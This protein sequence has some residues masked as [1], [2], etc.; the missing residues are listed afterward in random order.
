MN[1][2]RLSAFSLVEVVIALGIFA[3][4]AVGI[5]GLLPVAMDATRAVS[6]EC[7][8]N[9]IAESISGFWQVSANGSNSG[10]DFTMGDFTVGSTGN[11]TIYYNNFGTVV[12]T[13]DDAT[14]QLFYDVQDL[15]GYPN[16][17]TVN[18]TFSWPANAPQTSP[19]V[20]RR[21]FN[22]IFTK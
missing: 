14:M 3:F 7:N 22:Y 18:L 4:C 10:N 20:N 12:G 13:A 6:Q 17:F 19:N 21:Y 2:D 16:S 11:S 8:A 1:Q 5:V 9:N 15:T